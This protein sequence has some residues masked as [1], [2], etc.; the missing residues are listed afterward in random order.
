MKMVA[1][2]A[3]FNILSRPFHGLT[4]QKTVNYTLDKVMSRKRRGRP[5]APK[6][7]ESYSPYLLLMK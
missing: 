2:N 3:S 7:S 5:L 1:I 4:A 6:L